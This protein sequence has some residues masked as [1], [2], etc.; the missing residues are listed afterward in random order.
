MSYYIY[1]YMHPDYAWLYVGQT[2]DIKGRIKSHD[3]SNTDNIDRKYEDLLKEA[4]VLYFECNSKNQMN[5]IESYLID[6]HKPFLNK[7]GKDKEVSCETEMKLPDWIVYRQGIKDFSQKLCHISEEIEDKTKSLSEIEA[8]TKQSREELSQLK[9]EIALLSNSK[10]RISNEVNLP[11]SN[12]K[13]V[14]TKMIDEFYEVF[15]DSNITFSATAWGENG[16]KSTIV[17]GNKFMEVNMGD[18]YK[19]DSTNLLH[20]EDD[21]HIKKGTPNFNGHFYLAIFTSINNGLYPSTPL[22]FSLLNSYYSTKIVE[23]GCEIEKIKSEVYVCKAKDVAFEGDYY[24][25]DELGNVDWDSAYQISYYNNDGRIEWKDFSV[26]DKDFPDTKAITSVYYDDRYE[27][28]NFY[29]EEIK[30]VELGEFCVTNYDKVLEIR[31]KEANVKSLQ[32][33]QEKLMR[34]MYPEIK[35]KTAS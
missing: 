20:Q 25:C 7:A 23:L 4:T 5:Y 15:P 13:A 6:K 34:I 19:L 14:G 2:V 12:G 33:K 28:K 32:D 27:N 8:K 11:F 30:E 18:D 35:L 1:R 22:F 26:F 31:Q 21:W 9:K 24:R 16:K 3:N 29:L 17:Y 10:R